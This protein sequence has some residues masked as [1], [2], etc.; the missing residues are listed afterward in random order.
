[1]FQPKDPAA[2]KF[3][4]QFDKFTII[5]CGTA[6]IAYGLQQYYVSAPR[7]L[8]F[9]VLSLTRL[10]DAQGLDSTPGAI[11]KEVVVPKAEKGGA[12]ET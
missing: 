12:A 8:P 10:F 4:R 11:P 3:V 5:L 6:A 1:M 7:N 2:R 9:H